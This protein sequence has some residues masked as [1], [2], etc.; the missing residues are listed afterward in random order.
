MLLWLAENATRTHKEGRSK[1]PHRT[2]DYHPLASEMF[3]ELVRLDKGHKPSCPTFADFGDGIAE[4][5]AL[6]KRGGGS[7]ELAKIAVA[8]TAD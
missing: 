3:S 2:P 6:T 1:Q 4:A 8:L 7:A 5:N